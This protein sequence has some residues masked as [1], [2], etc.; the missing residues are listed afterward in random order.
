MAYPFGNPT[1]V[2]CWSRPVIPLLLFLIVLLRSL[3]GIA[4][5]P[6]VD[7]E[8][9]FSRCETLLRTGA[10][11]SAMQV[12]SLA[13]L[14]LASTLP[15]A[16]R[17]RLKS[18][19]GIIHHM[20]GDYNNALNDQLKALELSEQADSPTLTSEVLNNIGAIHHIQDNYA[21]ALTYYTACLGLREELGNKKDLALSYNNFGSLYEDMGRFDDARANLSKSIAYWEELGDSSWIAVTYTNLGSTLESEGDFDAALKLYQQSLSMFESIGN[22]SQNGKVMAYIGRVLIK[23]NDPISARKWCNKS[24]KIANQWS[25]SSLNMQS[26]QCLQQAADLLGKPIEAYDYFQRYVAYRDSLSSQDLTRELTKLE[27]DYSFKKQLLADS[28]EVAKT[29]IKTE[30]E[31]N[32]RIAEQRNQ[33]NIFLLIGVGILLLAAGLA[34]RLRFIRKSRKK[35]QTERDRSDRLLLNILP[36]S[37]AE[38]LKSNGQAAAKDYEEVS[39]LFTDF[40]NFTKHSERL[41][42]HELLE[43]LNIYFRE[44]DQITLRHGLEK[45]KTIGDAYMVAGGLPIPD[46]QAVKNTI[47]AGLEM[48]EFITKVALNRT[49]ENKQCFEMRLGIHTGPI[50]AGI[51]GD[52]KFQYDIWGD[53]VNTASRLESHAEAGLVNISAQTFLLVKDEIDLR[54][55]PRGKIAVKGKG[56][57]EMYYVKR[58]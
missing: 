43:E 41:T 55:E 45:I 16:Q 19:M 47:L 40:V 30:F 2:L 21:D 17:A 5:P 12:L 58:V 29:K 54:F 52:V 11:D 57:L 42:A 56:E 25:S 49:R 9:Y 3:D 48:Q 39:V 28:L 27:M 23:K 46:Q 14:E 18:K 1:L 22:G 37:V 38:E 24:L 33:R 20:R 8:Q 13:E 51:V 31:F 34:H 36:A 15:L 10:L 6:K 4:Q 53:T 26:C 44:F 35:I 7:I 50:V 32:E